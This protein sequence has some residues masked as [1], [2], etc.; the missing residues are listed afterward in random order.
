[1][2]KE[3]YLD[4]LL[5]ALYRRELV[6]VYQFA[7]Q[8]PEATDDWLMQ[9]RH[10]AHELVKE[11]LAAYHDAEHTELKLTHYGRYWMLQGGYLSFLKQEHDLKDKEHREKDHHKEELLEARLRLT[12]YRLVLFWLMLVVTLISLGLSTLNLWL[13]LSHKKTF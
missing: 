9:V 3:E 1:M 12:R 5:Q 8:Q 10:W 6:N 2:L 4:K 11:K 7:A 13:Y